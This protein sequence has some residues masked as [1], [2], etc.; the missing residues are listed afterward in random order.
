MEF[1]NP[2]G[3]QE[4]LP[5]PQ[6]NTL[7]HVSNDY[8]NEVSSYLGFLEMGLDTMK[9]HYKTG[10]LEPLKTY[11]ERYPERTYSSVVTDENREVVDQIN[12]RVAHINVLLVDIDNIQEDEL[13][14]QLEKVVQLIR[15]TH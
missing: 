1:E 14:Q 11:Q 3:S 8:V 7:T 4:K 5:I 9:Q 10:L 6:L 13:K 15:G 2:L 12:D